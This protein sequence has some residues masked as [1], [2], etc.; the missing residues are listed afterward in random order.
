MS[1]SVGSS[2]VLVEYR[3]L[4]GLPLSV[5]IGDRW[6]SGKDFSQVPVEE[7]WVVDEGLGMDGVV[8]HDNG[9]RV[10][11]TSAESTSHEVDNPCI[12]KPASH[13]EV[14]DW[15]FSNEEKAKEASELGARSVVSPVE[16]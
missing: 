9:A 2:V 4:S 5:C 12:S 3:G 8:V 14:L 13:V 7:V 6:V 1:V 11:E 15:E 10:A 16:V